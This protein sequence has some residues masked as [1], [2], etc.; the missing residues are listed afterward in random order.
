MINA[1]PS[2]GLIAIIKTIPMG[3]YE[4]PRIK[5]PDTLVL[6]F[7]LLFSFLTNT[8]VDIHPTVTRIT[9]SNPGIMSV[10][11]IFTGKNG[12]RKIIRYIL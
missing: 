8:N 9:K 5:R 1:I 6:S 3:I 4:I 7:Y 2:I 12:D 10:H 11:S